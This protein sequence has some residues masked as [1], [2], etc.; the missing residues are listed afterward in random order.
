MS[1][2]EGFRK[3]FVSMVALL[4]AIVASGLTACSSD[5]PPKGVAPLTRADLSASQPLP[6]PNGTKQRTLSTEAELSRLQQSLNADHITG[7]AVD[8]GS[9][10]G[11]TGGTTYTI[12]LYRAESSP[13]TL[14]AYR[15]G[16]KE[17]GN[18]KGDRTAF[19]DDI[20][21]FLSRTGP[22]A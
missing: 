15:C 18:I 11:C 10:A 7:G 21:M 9:T 19:L 17:S 13:E 3:L 22:F 6:P 14:T 8:D 4:A 12:V 2:G 20:D 1:T 16:G 5:E